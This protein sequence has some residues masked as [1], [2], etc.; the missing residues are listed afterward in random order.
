MVAARLPR[1]AHAGHGVGGLVE[2]YAGAGAAAFERTERDWKALKR[3]FLLHV[4]FI[5]GFA[6]SVRGYSAVAA[7]QATPERRTVLLKEARRIGRRLEGERMPWPSATAALIAAGTANVEG[8]RP[9]TVAALRTAI[10]RAEA[11]DMPFPAA[12]AR[13][14]LGSLSTVPRP[15]SSPRLPS[16]PSAIAASATSIA[17]PLCGFLAAGSAEGLTSEDRR[18]LL[19]SFADA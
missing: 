14:R 11:I 18:A 6:F 3:S 15:E 4:Q 12:A 7:A 13:Y 16:G 9:R 19:P 1:A 17:L 8:D 10:V 5:R 2:L